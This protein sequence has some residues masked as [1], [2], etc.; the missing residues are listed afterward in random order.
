MHRQKKPPASAGGIN[1]RWQRRLIVLRKEVGRTPLRG[2]LADGEPGSG[3]ARGELPD[4]LEVARF[5]TNSQ[6]LK[7]ESVAG[8]AHGLRG[9]WL[10]L[11]GTVSRRGET[12]RV[13]R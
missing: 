9:R 11:P 5:R 6:G 4:S 7:S 10:C 1:G 3:L 12:H 2:S 13:E 8:I